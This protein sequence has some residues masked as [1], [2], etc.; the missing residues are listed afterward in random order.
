M[1]AR[2]FSKTALGTSLLLVFLA[3][4]LLGQD[5][6]EPSPKPRPSSSPAS[7]NTSSKS[8]PSANNTA[9]AR[10]SLLIVPDVACKVSVDDK[11]LGTLLP[12]HPRSVRVELGDHVIEARAI[13]GHGEWQDT[14]TVEKPVQVAVKTQIKKVLADEKEAAARQAEASARQAEALEQEKRDAAARE[15]QAAETRRKESA[16]L[17]AMAG[18]WLYSDGKDT[19]EL[20]MRLEGEAL[21][22]SITQAR[23]VDAK[24]HPGHCETVQE[25]TTAGAIAAGLSGC[26]AACMQTVPKTYCGPEKI[27]PAKDYTN[28][29]ALEGRAR[30]DGTVKIKGAY[31]RCVGECKAVSN[32]SSEDLDEDS[33]ELRDPSALYWYGRQFKRQ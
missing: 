25:T 4:Q 2:S 5:S 14:V 32:P 27:T 16:E 10:A 7:A 21:V 33:A 3:I 24:H 15:V 23:H 12:G 22:G 8:A 9:P 28:Y 18:R 30:P 1:S 29:F 6:S 19:L 11:D 26:G 17:A 13:S 20:S 31:Q